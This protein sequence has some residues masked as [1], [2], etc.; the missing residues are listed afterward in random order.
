MLTIDLEAARI[1]R[2]AIRTAQQQPDRVG[3]VA[4]QEI[5]IPV[6]APATMIQHPS[7]VD[8]NLIQ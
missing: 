4:G 3:R 8:T 5:G 1:G 2:A 6:K 7:Q